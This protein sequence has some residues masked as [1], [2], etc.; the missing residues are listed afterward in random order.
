MKL[1]H[2]TAAFASIV[3]LTIAVPALALELR[4][5]KAHL[6]VDVPDGWTTEESKGWINSHPTDWS[7]G[8]AVK[9]V[10]HSIWKKE[11]DFEEGIVTY[12]AEHLDDVTIDTHAKRIENWHHYEGWEAWGHGKRKSDGKS[13]KFFILLLRDEK[14]PSKGAIFL[15]HGT[16]DGFEKHH[17]G[18]YDSLHSLRTY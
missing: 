16:K 5:P 9:G 13:V 6:V 18:I 15:G 12:Y 1:R 7:F 4:E 17:K 2:A 10:D 8:L 11:K 3:A 14:A